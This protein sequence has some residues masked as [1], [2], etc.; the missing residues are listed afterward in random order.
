MEGRAIVSEQTPTLSRE[1]FE[2]QVRLR[3]AQ[4]SH[5]LEQLLADPKAALASAFGLELPPDMEFNVLQETP[6]RFYLVLPVASKELTDN[7]LEA[8][9]GGAGLVMM[10]CT[11]GLSGAGLVTTSKWDYTAA[12]A[13]P[14]W[15]W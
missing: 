12:A 5:F 6:S 8:A 4:D 10:K 13:S 3:A 11:A 9:A 2:R 14:F 1:E 7:E 15:K